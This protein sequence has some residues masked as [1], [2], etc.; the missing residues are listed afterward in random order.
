M[1]RAYGT[2]P[3][4][5]TRVNGLKPVV[6][7]WIEPTALQALTWQPSLPAMGVKGRCC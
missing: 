5:R 6:T 1:N 7:R 2:R 4:F 3:A